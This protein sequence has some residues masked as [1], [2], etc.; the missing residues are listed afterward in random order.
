MVKRSFDREM[1][2]KPAN[3]EAQQMD[4]KDAKEG[5]PG[6][7]PGEPPVRKVYMYDGSKATSGSEKRGGTL[8]GRCH[9]ME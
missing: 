9:K 3:K 1:K 2:K 8:E 4:E 5:I 7:P 6:P